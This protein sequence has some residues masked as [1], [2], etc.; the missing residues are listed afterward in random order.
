MKAINEHV[1]WVLR[2]TKREL[3]FA[4]TSGEFST[5]R[6]TDTKSGYL[7]RCISAPSL[8]WRSLSVNAY[9]DTSRSQKQLLQST[10]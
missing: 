4:A 9:A 7:V 2:Q 6:T 10:D 3:S 1:G 5:R 8:S